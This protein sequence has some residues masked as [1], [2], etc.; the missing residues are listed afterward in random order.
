[1][2]GE[3]SFAIR[4]EREVGRAPVAPAERAEMGLSG[5]Q[6]SAGNRAVARL[7]SMSRVSL[8][9]EV[10]IGAERVTH[11]SR[12]VGELFDAV[13]VPE[14][15]RTGHKTYGVKAQLVKFVRLGGPAPGAPPYADMRVFGQKFMSWLAEQQR[16]VRGGGTSP[17]LKPFSVMGMS[18]P[19][20]SE[21]LRALKGVQ[22]GDDLRHVVRNATLKTALSVEFDRLLPDTRKPH[23]TA[24]A[25]ELGVTLRPNM[26]LDRVV[27]A[28]YKKLYLNPENLFAGPAPMNRLIGFAATPV[29]DFGEKL[30]DMGDE[31]IKIAEV[32]GQVM[33]LIAEAAKIISDA[34]ERVRLVSQVERTIK[35][36]IDSLAEDGSGE[37]PAEEAGDLVADIGLNFGFDL[38]AG[39]TPKDSGDI[40]ARQER[41]LAS[42][43]DLDAFIRDGSGDLLAILR[44]FLEP[45]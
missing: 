38:I 23:F 35:E 36:A 45:A 31:A 42:E 7:L 40:K 26:P 21:G 10:T 1:V 3:V 39:R 18:R 30:V 28:I 44:R 29:R 14:L 27:E 16:P 32:Y 25:H 11:G 15:E 12:R 33:A 4:R 41:L 8:A 34:D 6:R 5:L 43:T 19:N 37:A 2:R 9:R 20:W 13:I 22:P 17:V 24:M